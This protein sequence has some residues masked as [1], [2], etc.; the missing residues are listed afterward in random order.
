MATYII[1][2]IIAYLLGS[3]SFSVIISK[4][5]AGFDVREKGSGNAGTTNV[6]RTVGKKA[7]ALTLLFDA[8]KGV[9]EAIKER[10]KIKVEKPELSEEMAI[11][12]SYKLNQVKKG[13]IVKIVHY[14]NEEYIETFGM[15]SEFS[16]VFNYLK[17]VKK[18]I[19]FENILDIQSDEIIEFTID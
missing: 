7:S 1:V 16:E 5:M 9:K 15:V 17:I 4:K 13:M 6:L 18:K 10:Q 11:E 8:L 12:L 19:L 14:D 3:I 2:T